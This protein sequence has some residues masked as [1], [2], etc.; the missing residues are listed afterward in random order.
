MGMSR[1]S[2]TQD[3]EFNP[4][5]G[6]AKLL[7]MRILSGVSPITLGVRICQISMVM[8]LSQ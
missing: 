6:A 5:E 7:M 8:S 1:N 2:N 3:V 4:L